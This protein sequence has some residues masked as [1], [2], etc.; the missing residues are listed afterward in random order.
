[1]TDSL[2]AL[3]G[4]EPVAPGLPRT[5]RLILDVSS[6]A[7]WAGP[8]VGIARVE[9]ELAAYV[10]NSRPDIILS[11]YDS[12]TDT[13]R[14]LRPEWANVVT[15]WRGTIDTVRAD[16]RRHRRGWRRWLPSRYRAIMALERYRA[17]TQ[18]A[19]V[20]R[21]LEALQ[22]LIF[23]FRKPAF[24]FTDSLG[25]RLVVLPLDVAV[26]EPLALG[27][28]D[29]I[30][31]AGADW[32]HK[33]A[34]TID[35]LKQRFGFRY[36]VLCYD[37][38]P[39]LYPKFYLARDFE[40]FQTYW[41]GMFGVADKVIVNS[42]QV[43]SDVLTYCRSVGVR[44]PDTAVRPLGHDPSS[45]VPSGAIPHPS[46]L[47]HERFAL[48]VSTIEPRKGH[49]L[50]VRVW[51]RLLAAGVPQRHR[52]KLVFVGRAGW[53]V[54]AVLK[55]IRNPEGFADTLIWLSNLE[56]AELQNLYQNAAFCLY[57]SRYEGFGL[58][59]I[60]A[61]S[62]GKAVIASTGGA[63]PETVGNL[64]PCLDPLDEDAWYLQLQRWIEDPAVRQPYEARIRA[65][66][67]HP[68]WN[69]AAAQIFAAAGDAVLR[70]SSNPGQADEPRLR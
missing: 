11:F 19:P 49:E 25:R 8:A 37:I 59:I 39:L 14:V 50:L 53:L 66:F 31:S 33:P 70:S 36:V 67:A 17:V 3:P 52:F 4:P 68:R 6:I 20:V 46:G 54:D 22:L 12:T 28:D 40:I 23:L 2:I 34:D 48:F 21:C 45:A 27:P 69:E 47:E 42:R 60:E 55:R 32:Y 24:P 64:S 10:L 35:R 18:S 9:H 65:S 44:P 13:F 16:Y 38:I 56:D 63:V 30:L 1:M 43:Q 61:F 15:G 58:P 51:E 7:R 5:P 29:I 62:H 41:R 57:P 26:G